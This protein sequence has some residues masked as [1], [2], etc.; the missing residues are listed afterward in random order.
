MDKAISTKSSA[1]PT[2]HLSS[3]KTLQG[4]EFMDI[5]AEI[6]PLRLKEALIKKTCGGWLDLAIDIDAII[7]FASGFEDIIRPLEGSL[8][9]L[10]HM[11]RSVP[12]ENDYLAA[13]IP[14]IK[15]LFERSGSRLTKK[16]LTSTHL[17]WHQGEVLFEH[18]RER[19][20][21]F[22]CTCERLQQVVPDSRLTVGTRC[23]AGPL[24]ERGA[25]IFG[26]ATYRPPMSGLTEPKADRSAFYSQRNCPLD[27][28]TDRNES[29]GSSSPNEDG[30]QS[31]VSS[32]SRTTMEFSSEVI[33]YKNS[34][35]KEV[36]V[37][38]PEKDTDIDRS[39]GPKRV[40]VSYRRRDEGLLTTKSCSENREASSNMRGKG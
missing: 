13:S 37:Q 16:H 40:R 8:E 30:S 5:F 19:V 1:E 17:Q 22:H 29:A 34:Q 10:C 7:L 39:G 9:G 28:E 36:G 23:P 26:Q 27:L 6:S 32:S 15:K 3:R 25:V 31:S 12:K 21:S 4:W 2:I 11:W 18:C 24:E 14:T 38:K 35:E 33:K 20:S